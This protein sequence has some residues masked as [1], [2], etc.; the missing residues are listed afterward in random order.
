MFFFFHFFN[1]LPNDQILD[2]P[3]LK[4]FADDK[5]K[6]LKMIIVVFE[7]V[8]NIVEKGENAGFLLFP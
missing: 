4:A 8:E 5:I 2:W 6:A 3:K 7:R 1:S